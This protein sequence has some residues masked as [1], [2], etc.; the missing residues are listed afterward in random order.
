[1]TFES[2]ALL[3]PFY[4]DD[5]RCS[6][7]ITVYE[8][9]N[10]P[11]H[12]TVILEHGPWLPQL[13]SHTPSCYRLSRTVTLP[14]PQARRIQGSVVSCDIQVTKLR[15]GIPLRGFMFT[16]EPVCI[17]STGVH[18]NGLEKPARSTGDKPQLRKEATASKLASLVPERLEKELKVL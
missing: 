1:M 17:P 12:H 4:H 16:S 11:P 18:E 3:L 14:T 13:W 15:G 8:A 10:Q 7:V 9:R 6:P 5:H 2:K